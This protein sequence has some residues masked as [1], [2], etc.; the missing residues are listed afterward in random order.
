MKEYKIREYLKKD[1]YTM[2]LKNKIDNQEYIQAIKVKW[3]KVYIRYYKVN[4]NSMELEVNKDILKKLNELNE[5]QPNRICYNDI[6]NIQNNEGVLKKVENDAIKEWGKLFV[7]N[8]LEGCELFAKVYGD[9]FALNQM[10]KIKKLY[11][12]NK[13]KSVLGAQ[14][15]MDEIILYCNKFNMNVKEIYFVNNA[16]NEPI[17]VLIKAIKNSKFGLKIK[18][19]NNAND[20]KTYKNVFEGDKNEI[21]SRIR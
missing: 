1:G 8:K 2:V 12:G 13:D 21:N 10:C 20:L 19:L 3:N 4:E 17:L 5:N 11:I 16:N 15:G 7:A 6:N 14:N 9:T 18:Y